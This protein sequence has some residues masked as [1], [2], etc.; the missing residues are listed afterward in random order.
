VG[1]L[2]PTW[3]QAL[4]EVVKLAAQEPEFAEP[5]PLH[6]AADRESLR[7][8]VEDRLQAFAHWV[9][10]A[11]ADEIAGRLSRRF[12]TH[13][14][15]VLAGQLQ[16]VLALGSLADGTRMRRR[17]GS[18]L[19]LERLD[20]ELAASLGDRELRMPVWVEPA[21]R[22]VAESEQFTVADLSPHLD[23]Q[24]RLVLVR[25]LVREGL[26]EIVGVG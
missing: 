6:F 12:L 16:Q 3:R 24:S 20:G 14:H 8:A 5:L 22:A 4:D 18:M 11:D 21:M 7:R 13:R 1:I 15:P 17:H 2:S 26:L 9:E 10:K 23:E 19:V 25:R